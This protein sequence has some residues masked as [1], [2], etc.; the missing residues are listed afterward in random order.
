[1]ASAYSTPTQFDNYV[2]PGNLDLVNFVL[3]SKEEKFNY[4]IAKVEQTLKD[5]GN[6]ELRRDED[7]QYLADRINT[8]LTSMG[9]LEHMDWSDNNV[10]RQITSGIRGAI[11]Q[12]VL[13]DVKKT[14]EY[15]NYLQNVQQIQE[16]DPDKYSDINFQM[17]LISSGADKWSRGEEGTFG[18]LQYTP[19]E[20][21]RQNRN[22]YI[23]EMVK[24]YGAERVEERDTGIKGITKLV[25]VK[26]LTEEEARSM[27][28]ASLT[29]SEQ[30]QLRMEADY[31]AMQI[32]EEGKVEFLERYDGVVR[33]RVEEFK[34]QNERHKALAAKAN[35]AEEKTFHTNQA[36]Q[37]EEGAKTLS[38][39]VGKTDF[40]TAFRNNYIQKVEDDVVKVNSFQR[41]T[42]I[43]RDLSELR[44]IK[45]NEEIIKLRTANNEAQTPTAHNFNIA[46]DG[47][48]TPS[49][50]TITYADQVR[51]DMTNATETMKQVITREAQDPET[52]SEKYGITGNEYTRKTAAEKEEFVT[53][54]IGDIEKEGIDAKSNLSPEFIQAYMQFNSSRSAFNSVNDGVKQ[55]TDDIAKT[56]LEA[57]KR[58]YKEGGFTAENFRNPLIRKAVVDGMSYE[59]MTEDENAAFR[60]AMIDESIRAGYIDDATMPYIMHNRELLID[61]IEDPN[62]RR[63]FTDENILRGSR[64]GNTVN[65]IAKAVKTGVQSMTGNVIGALQS[66]TELREYAREDVARG[67]PFDIFVSDQHF[68]ELTNRVMNQP[69]L[70]TEDGEGTTGYNFIQQSYEDASKVT[71]QE[72]AES[73]RRLSSTYVISLSPENETEESMVDR[74]LSAITLA[75]PELSKSDF[76][77]AD[78]EVRYDR[79]KGALQYSSTITTATARYLDDTPRKMQSAWIPIEQERNNIPDLVNRLQ[80]DEDAWSLDAGNKSATPLKYN[81]SGFEDDGERIRTI[82]NLSRG[83]I[84][85]EDERLHLMSDKNRIGFKNKDLQKEFRTTK[86]INEEG[87]TVNFAQEFPQA[88][89]KI[90][91]DSGKFEIKYEPIHN[92]GYYLKVDYR[93]GDKA[94]NIYQGENSI[95]MTV[96]DRTKRLEA[97][98]IQRGMLEE[99]ARGYATS[100]DR[101]LSI[102]GEIEDL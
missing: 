43:E 28:A 56:T 63:S 49:E 79:S 57:M 91:G 32:G 81:I 88:Y 38:S 73:A 24:T 36:E 19:Y 23:Q 48:L 65:A 14:R 72:A 30:N 99:F 6:L 67:T 90:T 4:N 25:T 64:I 59:E 58:G 78:V 27:Y 3:Q 20:N 53:T 68:G 50:T 77:G 66:A 1:M 41:E 8:M 61:E 70:I 60:V 71:Q 34:K 12:R 31:N 45:L 89:E 42:K 100:N 55:A 80:T 5:F 74:S 94:T 98:T 10:E 2:Q 62:L 26:G 33:S 35:K 101:I 92:R 51:E 17:G 102:L 54:I 76:R 18:N 9:D 82:E 44:A 52:F 46:S 37:Y 93:V 39:T 21:V 16:K 84:L 15:N 11:D 75:N 22:E 97:F 7:K 96:D 40:E 83:G 85:T 95:G 13:H 86:R 47:A 29:P 87:R 69:D